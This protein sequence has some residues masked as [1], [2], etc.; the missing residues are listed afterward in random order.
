[1]DRMV[2]AFRDWNGTQET[3]AHDA[4]R[5]TRD[6]PMIWEEKY[7]LLV[8]LSHLL[9]TPFDLE[10]IS[11]LEATDVHDGVGQLSIPPGSP[12]VA[13]IM[14]ADC[15]QNLSCPGREREAAKLLLVRLALRP[16]MQNFG[17]LESLMKWFLSHFQSSDP[18]PQSIHTYI[19]ILSF[20]NG[21]LASHEKSTV[22]PYVTS[23]FDVVQGIVAQDS[24]TSQ[25][26]FSSASGR[27]LLVKL[28]RSVAL[29]TLRDDTLSFLSNKLDLVEEILAVTVNQLL[30]FLAD[31]DTPVRRAASKALSVIT[32]ALEPS[33]ANDIIEA[34]KTALEENV[35]WEE[36]NTGRA[37]RQDGILDLKPGL[38]KRNLTAISPLRWHGLVL[39]LSYLIYRR[40]A[41]T[42]QLS[43][44]LNALI[45]A[46]GFEQRSSSGSS[47]GTNV[48]D[49]ACFGMWAL[50]RRYTTEELLAVS[51][52]TS[53]IAKERTSTSCLHVLSCELVAA[54][55]LDPSG[56]IRRGASA[57]LQELIGRH[58]DTIVQGIPL[59]QTVDYQGVSLRSR[60]MI[61]VAVDAARLDQL[62]EQSSVA[63]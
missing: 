21:I 45:L 55:T 7:I 60:A 33:W 15:G 22:A 49:A 46:L 44:I 2:L 10:S 58:P 5:T 16:D 25:E 37:I 50:A 54:A 30:D 13:R 23:A 26:I 63:C 19:G 9:L 34:I 53:Y 4:L 48:R 51:L 20:L 32:I 14:I 62:Y 17:L 1:M 39:T 8:W 31:K 41:P 28:F 42:E 59:V 43:S 24:I 52:S 57:A 27:K 3:A 18:S 11:S 6:D 61:E 29:Q 12:P 40:S 47:I 36:V 38:L 56:N 35:L